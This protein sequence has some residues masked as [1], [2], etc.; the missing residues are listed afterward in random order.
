MISLNIVSIKNKKILDLIVS[1]K[2][3]LNCDFCYLKNYKFKSKIRYDK[4]IKVIEDINPDIVVFLAKEALLS[5][6]DY[7]I[8]IIDSF[9][10]KEFK[11]YTNLTISLSVSGLEIT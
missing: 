11:L 2:C 10:D 7:L 9:P 3:N 1:D 4:Y 8:K 5:N 6:I